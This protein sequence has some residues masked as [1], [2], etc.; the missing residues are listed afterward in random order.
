MRSALPT[1]TIWMSDSSDV[2]A[3]P[4]TTS[5]G[6]KSPPIAS[7]AI[8][9]ISSPP[10][11]ALQAVHQLPARQAKLERLAPVHFHHGDL[12]SVPRGQRRIAVHVHDPDGE[13]DLAARLLDLGQGLLAQAAVLP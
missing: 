9:G 8:F 5:S 12:V 1:R 3:T 13:I 7:T 11:R 4:R 10:P 2:F 6:A